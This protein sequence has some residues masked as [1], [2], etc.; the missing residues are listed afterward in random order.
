MYLPMNEPDDDGRL[1]MVGVCRRPREVLSEG[2]SSGFYT[3]NCDQADRTFML[4]LC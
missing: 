4:K 3:E 2:L 1:L